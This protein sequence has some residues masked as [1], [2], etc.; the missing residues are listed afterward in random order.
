MASYITVN[1]RCENGWHEFDSPQVPGL[2]MI[3]EQNDL[4]AAYADIPKAIEM[5]IRADTG[6]EVR[7]RQEETYSEYLERL[8]E[9][10]LPSQRYYSIEKL[11]A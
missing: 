8:P 11:A 1:H 5:L 3:V 2:F 7:V 6:Q 4:E 10:H 9:S